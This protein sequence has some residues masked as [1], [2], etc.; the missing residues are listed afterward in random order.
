M[1][2]FWKKSKKY[3][4]NETSFAVGAEIANITNQL[5]E[6]LIGE[7]GEISNKFRDILNQDIEEPLNEYEG[8]KAVEKIFMG[9]IGL[10]IA[11]RAEFSKRIENSILNGEIYQ[12]Y[13]GKIEEI[14]QIYVVVNKRRREMKSAQ[15]DY[16]KQKDVYDKVF[17]A[18]FIDKLE[19]K[20]KKNSIFKNVISFFKK[21]G[22]HKDG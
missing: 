5:V 10:A 7:N 17:G 15:D 20:P 1:G 14:S 11:K 2:F 4:K 19:E 6:E 9:Y 13:Y 8:K 18:S 21:D 12:Q 16:D 3:N 22:E